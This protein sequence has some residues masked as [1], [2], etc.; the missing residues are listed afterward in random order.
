MILRR[1]ANFDVR[2]FKT[3][4]K[5]RDGSFDFTAFF[6]L[7]LLNLDDSNR[8]CLL[9]GILAYLNWFSTFLPPAVVLWVEETICAIVEM[10]CLSPR[11][12]MYVSKILGGI[13]SVSISQESRRAS[14]V[15]GSRMTVFVTRTYCITADSKEG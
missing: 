11:P 1:H 4:W 12:E 8:G 15:T 5:F 13:G 14:H 7:S 3:S 2:S 9:A 10:D 6:N